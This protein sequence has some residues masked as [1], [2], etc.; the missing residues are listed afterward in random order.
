[1]SAVLPQADDPAKPA[2][3]GFAFVRW[4]VAAVVVLFVP[5]LVLVGIVGQF[6]DGGTIAERILL[7]VVNPVAIVLAARTMLDDAF[8]ARRLA[9]AG[10]AGAVAL[11]ANAVAA[12]SIAQGWSTGDVE[13]PLIFGIPFVA[14]VPYAAKHLQ[15]SE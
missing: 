6:A 3:P 8:Y 1:M 2:R 13:I 7:G 15:S 14:F 4:A 10:A 11:I 5:I 9:W 12:V